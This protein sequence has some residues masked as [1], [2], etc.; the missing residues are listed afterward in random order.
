MAAKSLQRWL[1]RVCKDGCK[2]FAKVAA[3]S[4][5]THTGLA[6][7]ALLARWRALTQICSR[8]RIS[9]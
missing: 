9:G 4:L 1:Q 3:K 7:A 6:E 8:A 2:E 5:Q